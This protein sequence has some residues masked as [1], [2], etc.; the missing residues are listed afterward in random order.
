MPNSLKTALLAI[1][2]AVV[3]VALVFAG[4][5]LGMNPDIRGAVRGSFGCYQN[6]TVEV[7]SDLLAE[8][9]EQLE[10]T[11]YKDIDPET[12]V[13]GAIDGILAKL[14]DPY[15]VYYDPQEYA[16][17]LEEAS[18]AYS[19]VGMA[20]GMQD[21][22][23][24]IA[25]VFADS[26]ADEADI[27]A[28]DIVLSVDSAPVSGQ[29]LEEVVQRIKGPEG[30]T[31]VLEM[32]RPAAISTTST[33][34]ASGAEDGTGNDLAEETTTST[35]ESAADLSRLPPGG[36]TK[37]YTLVRRTIVIHTTEM[38][39]LDAT[40]QKVALIALYTFYNENAG[41]ELRAE[42]KKA[43]EEDQ[44]DAIILDL[45]GN[46]GGLL[47]EAIEV[48]SIFIESGVIVST[49]GLHSAVE[50]YSASGDAYDDVPLY[51]LT[52]EGSASASEIV[53]AALQDYGRATLV[54]ETTFGKALVQSIEPL[55]NLGALKVTTAVYL[56]PKGRDINATGV[57]PD[58]VAPDD[59]ETEDVDETVEKV[60]DLIADPTAGR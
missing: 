35:A 56:T 39:T 4:F 6:P 42:V 47:T 24:T 54:G 57:S 10:T 29:T 43:V 12:I 11:Y 25:S 55:S 13:A 44:V 33:T 19:G 48:A 22:L 27:R 32:Y 60:L 1:A 20:V 15:T 40:G 28:G 37:V 3:A 59:P 31:V 23:V 18:G 36:T 34:V 7:D 52:D 46:G 21:R 38:A 30:T 41:E 2:T 17:L 14:N 9:V 50:V 53:S 51:V 58:I 45:R 49:E 16:A 8:I 5:V 26:P